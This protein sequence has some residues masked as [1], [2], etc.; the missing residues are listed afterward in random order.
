MISSQRV[1][2]MRHVL[3]GYSYPNGTMDDFTTFHKQILADAGYDVVLTT[4][5]DRISSGADLLQLPR[6]CVP[7]EMN[8]SGF[9][10]FLTH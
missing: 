4:I 10:Y 2:L 7:G 5:V 3:S 1:Y 9:R 8:I 6:Y